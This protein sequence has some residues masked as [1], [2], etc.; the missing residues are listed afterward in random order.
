MEKIIG[1]FGILAG[2]AYLLYLWILE[3]KRKHRRMEELIVFLQKSIFAMEEERIYVIEYFKNYVSREKILEESLHE[4]AEDLEKKVYPDGRM[5]W[6]NVFFR[7]KQEWGLDA[8]TFEIV[9]G[10]GKGFFGRSRGENVCFMQ[11]DLLKLEEQLGKRRETDAKERKV[12]IP[13]GMLGGIM[14]MIILV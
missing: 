5:V 10:M 9:T 4:I 14:L 6:E 13:V 2:I 8:D 11:R 12:W 1:M 3:Q 7:K